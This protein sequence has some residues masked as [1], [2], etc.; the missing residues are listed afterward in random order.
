MN[1]L[2]SRIDRMSH[3]VI[4]AALHFDLWSVHIRDTAWE[5]TSTYRQDFEEVWS[6][7]SL[8]HRFA[9][10]VRLNA[11][12]DEHRKATTIP[13]LLRECR[14]EF[15]A[16]VWAQATGRLSELSP[17]IAKVRSLR[18]NIYAHQSK[19]LSVKAAYAEVGISMD[20]LAAL[21]S[22][23]IDLMNL[24]RESRN[25][26]PI[27]VGRKHLDQFAEIIAAIDRKS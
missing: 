27:E 8:A 18:N 13:Q 11:I 23:S 10:Y 19:S 20:E 6:L 14:A 16:D 2:Q 9:F 26:E 15:D 1:D 4:A 7:T 25:L 24:I 12:Y 21:A 22:G 17:S 3:Q 5:A